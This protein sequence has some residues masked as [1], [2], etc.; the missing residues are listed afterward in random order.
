[1]K[2]EVLKR[3]VAFFIACAMLVPNFSQAFAQENTADVN[4]A[5]EEVTSDE[6][7][8]D[9]GDGTISIDVD[10]S[11][12]PSESYS[13][14]VRANA[15]AL[16]YEK[17]KDEKRPDKEIIVNGKDFIEA[18]EDT[19]AT[20]ETIDGVEALRWE[21][22][23]GSVSF[24]INVEEAGIYNIM[25]SYYVLPSNASD[26]E[27]SLLI[28]GESPNNA[29]RII[30]LNKIWV[31]DPSSDAT[32]E[33]DNDLRPA[34]IESPSWQTRTFYDVDG[35][36]TDP[37]I[38]Y[39]EK[40]EHIITLTS[41]KAHFAL[42]YLKIYNPDEL[43][44][45]ADIAPTEQDLANS[46]VIYKKLEG[47]KA[48]IKSEV[49]LY[50]TYDR[51][52]YL[53]SPS[54]PTKMRYNTIGKDNW[55]NSGE[56]ATWKFTVEE[57]GWVKIGIR[58][59]Q[60]TMRG[61]YSNRRLYIDGAV[62]CKEANQ[63][64][65]YYS[66]DWTVTTPSDANGEPMYFY[67]EAGE[68][69][70]TLE[71]IPGEIGAVMQR[72][73]DVVYELNSI[74]RSIVQITG[75]TP[76]AYTDYNI[77]KLIPGITDQLTDLANRL[78]SEK[79]YIE[80]LSGVTGSEAVSLEKA[81]EV[82]ER[83]VKNSDIIPS[84]LTQIQDYASAVSTW[85]ADYRMQY[86][87]LDMIEIVSPEADFTSTDKK[88]FKSFWFGIQSFIGSF[89][90]DYNSLSTA[91]EN[92]L[93]VWVSLGRDQAQ[94][95]NELVDNDFVP[96][97]GIPVAINLVQG[98]ILESTLAGKGPDVVLFIGG[99]LP[100]QLAARD[101]LVDLTKFD[102]YDEVVERFVE[103]APVLYTYQDGV[104]GLPITQS[105]PM[106]FYRTDILSEYG[107]E[108]PQTWDEILEILPVLQRNYMG[109]G[110]TGVDVFASLLLQN[111]L[112][113]YND[114]LTK[115]T[116]DDPIAIEC[117]EYWT[118]FYTTYSFE[119]TYDGFTRFR[120]GQY[121]VVFGAYTFYNQL[122]VAAPEINGLWDFTSIPGILQSDGTIN[123]L[124]V[125]GSTGGVIFNKL[126]EHDQQNAWEFLKW[127]TS[128]EVQASY[129]RTVESLLGA[130]GRFDP[131]NIN[132][133]S[134]LAWSRSDQEKILEQFNSLKENPVI[135][136]TYIV[137][138]NITNAFRM[139]VNNGEN[140]RETLL[141]YNDAIND[142]IIR[143]Y[144]DLGIDVDDLINK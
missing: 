35:L 69:T 42:E 119:Q 133:I 89:S 135:P 55:K 94:V 131:A 104:Y 1:M 142:E 102:D 122:A 50:P 4:T 118:K 3:S 48:D 141:W 70:I 66:T 110:L 113:Y 140:P 116:F 93:N 56:Y 138:R 87:E 132:A 32:D 33:N 126:N 36:F 85:M 101:V 11:S 53:T 96:S 64:K 143:K 26:V 43:P 128:T 95:I 127:F 98:G 62:P 121:P 49:T 91:D 38:F 46:P 20:V 22:E 6:S 2:N 9:S 117:F 27:L 65:F 83:C 40:G 63:I 73:D 76:D 129:G 15:Y 44:D 114:S 86:L 30:T 67:L 108:P 71:A 79:E 31:N 82:L 80:S 7:G 112:T 78:R 120:S 59:K 39:F 47:E 57:S 100:I 84:Y 29:A 58:A 134:E 137:G 74:Y 136:A 107:L 139:T 99:D 21:G 8:T 34:Q 5:A 41:E 90:E 17:Y 10:E 23:T 28:D 130:L 103:Y 52:S 60:E 111:G 16:Y 77:P 61:F 88:F 24:K 97:T 72:L 106:M 25:A 68:H 14:S 13:D 125:S 105:F 54:S 45:Y 81:A 144:E 51:T 37:L 124:T 75:P 92:A 18:S 109:I 12:N 123:H 19:G 115:T